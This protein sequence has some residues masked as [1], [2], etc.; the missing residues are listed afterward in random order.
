[1]FTFDD[2]PSVVAP[3]VG[4]ACTQPGACDRVAVRVITTAPA[5][6]GI[7][8]A[9]FN[10]N[11]HQ[12]LPAQRLPPPSVCRGTG[13]GS[14]GTSRPAPAVA[15]DEVAEHVDH[16]LCRSEREDREPTSGV[17]AHEREVGDRGVAVVDVDV[18]RGTRDR[19][20]GRER[21]QESACRPIS[22]RD[23]DHHTSSTAGIPAFPTAVIT[24]LDPRQP[25]R[26]LRPDPNACRRCVSEPPGRTANGSPVAQAVAQ[27]GQ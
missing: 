26:W 18:R 3:P 9:K 2:A 7:L 14:C 20:A 5:S 25:V 11:F 4:I 19:S 6:A 23:V 12:R 22:S 13:T 27:L 16:E 1:M 21:L 24:V 15:W 8:F 10:T 17:Q